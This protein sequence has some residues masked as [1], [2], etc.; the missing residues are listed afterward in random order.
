MIRYKLLFYLKTYFILIELL[1]NEIVHQYFPTE[2]YDPNGYFHRG[3][4]TVF[5]YYV[6][7]SIGYGLFPTE[8]VMKSIGA[9]T[10]DLYFP[11]GN[12]DQPLQAVKV[13]IRNF[14]DSKK[15]VFGLNT[16]IQTSTYCNY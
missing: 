7:H 9:K 14:V 4:E 5:D 10:R 15:S 2:M 16:I 8:S 12:M 1:F 6:T 13:S 3:L 11:G